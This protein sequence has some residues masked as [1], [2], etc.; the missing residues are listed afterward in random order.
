MGHWWVVYLTVL[1]FD[2]GTTAGGFALQF[3]GKELAIFGGVVIPADGSGMWL[4]A[5]LAGVAAAFLPES[6]GRVALTALAAIWK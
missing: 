2:I 3:A 1:T 5:T 4:V 6:I